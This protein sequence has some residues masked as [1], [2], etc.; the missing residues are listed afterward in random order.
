MVLM[1][2]VRRNSLLLLATLVASPA[3]A[4]TMGR[5][6]PWGA[7]DVAAAA[8]AEAA[9]ET[10][11]PAAASLWQ[12]TVVCDGEPEPVP[13]AQTLCP[14]ND[15][16]CTTV[17][18]H[19]VTPSGRPARS[20]PASSLATAADL[21]Q[22]VFAR[23]SDSCRSPKRPKSGIRGFRP[24]IAVSLAA[25]DGID[26]STLLDRRRSPVGASFGVT[27]YF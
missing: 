13:Q 6:D 18:E 2:C 11:R 19:A 8:K 17:L 3:V 22:Q 25:P 26:P 24:D 23:L 9:G 10:T 14:P 16:G 1:T 27:G 7:S 12:K 15:P 5:Y 4:G 20:V 21:A